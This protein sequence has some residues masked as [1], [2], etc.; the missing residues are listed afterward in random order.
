VKGKSFDTKDT[1]D[2][3]EIKNNNIVKPPS[4]V[5]SLSKGRQDAKEETGNTTA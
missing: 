4:P 2:T 1:K 5:L 3:K